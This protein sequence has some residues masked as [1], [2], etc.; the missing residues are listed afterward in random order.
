MDKERLLYKNLSKISIFPFQAQKE[1]KKED[2]CR[3]ENSARKHLIVLQ[4]L[5]NSATWFLI[6]LSS[7]WKSLL[8]NNSY[9]FLS[10][11]QGFL[12]S[13]EGLDY[14]IIYFKCCFKSFFMEASQ[15]SKYFIPLESS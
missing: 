12:F 2:S 15:F 6:F 1:G 13:C 4:V 5:F 9:L 3:R 11:A 10:L 8:V 7:L 14:L